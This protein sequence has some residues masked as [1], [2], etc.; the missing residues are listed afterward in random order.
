MN[1]LTTFQQDA[2][3]H[4]KL[5]MQYVEQSLVSAA[6]RGEALMGLINQKNHLS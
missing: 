6:R 2:V 3:F 4:A 5:A 1:E